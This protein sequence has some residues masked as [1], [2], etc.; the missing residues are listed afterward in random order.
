MS[1]VG[2][3]IRV[4]RSLPMR[5]SGAL[6]LGVAFL[7]L[8]AVLAVALGALFAQRNAEA[9]EQRSLSILRTIEQLR[10]ALID[11]ETGERG[12]LL[13]G[14]ISYLEPYRTARERFGR[15]MT[16]LR[17]LLLDSEIQSARLD[18]IEELSYLKLAEIQKT[19]ALIRSD[20]RDE[21][22]RLI[23]TDIGK[24][25]MDQIR[26]LIAQLVS[27]AQYLHSV[28]IQDSRTWLR[29]L[30]VLMTITLAAA[31]VLGIY[32]TSI[33]SRSA[34]RLGHSERALRRLNETL[35]DRVAE[36]TEQLN[37]A[38]ISAGRERD[39]VQALLGE[40]NHRIGNSLQLVSAY[41][42]LQARRYDDPKIVKACSS[43]SARISAIA[44]AQRRLK[45]ADDLQTTDTESFL[46]PV[47]EDLGKNMPERDLVAFDT[48]VEKVSISARNAVSI[49]V[50]LLELVTNAAKYA[51]PEGEKGAIGIA[52]KQDGDD[53]M[54]T[55]EDDG[56]GLVANEKK[57]SGNG[58]I[59]SLVSSLEGRIRRA[60]AKPGQPRPGLKVTVKFP[61]SALR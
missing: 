41:V 12:Y 31:A 38:L 7:M 44:A 36:R 54:L 26:V 13:A 24:G 51:F 22:V 30:L 4:R 42:G 8:I 2:G 23:R 25:Y 56:V 18:R 20:R 9:N 39:R 28:Q 59:S 6:A 32:G 27:D 48:H 34:V 10:V 15:H 40:L 60:P 5:D 47:I 19:I 57:G 52:V 50:I 17:A 55:V 58:I 53:L 14:D 49:S 29:R 3:N 21:A 11:A 37:N 35:E 45:L 1:V 43:V 16:T 61:L 46:V 33:L